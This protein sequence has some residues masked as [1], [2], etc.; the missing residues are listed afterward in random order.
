[1]EN[2][3]EISVFGKCELTK[4]D[5]KALAVA[6]SLSGFSLLDALK[7]IKRSEVFV[8]SLAKI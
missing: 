4:I 1:M 2:A 5:E 3:N 8:K 6:K 7:V